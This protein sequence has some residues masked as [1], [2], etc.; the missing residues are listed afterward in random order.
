MTHP[1]ELLKKNGLYAGKELG[2]NFLSNP[3]TACMI[4]DRTG[5]DKETTVLE[6]GPGLGAI[7]LPLARACK[8]VVAVEKDSRIIPLLERELADEGI[9]NVT[10]INQNILKTNIAQIAGTEKL[11]VIGNLPYNISSQILFQ[12]I[13]IRQ[14]IT[15][16][17]LMFQKELAERLLSPPGTKNYSRLSAVVQ[18]ASKISRVTDIRP[19]NFFP[20]PEVD[21]TVLR[22]DFFKTNGMGKEDE[23]LLFSVIKAAFSKRRKTLHNAMSGGELGL[24]KKIVG[25]AL[26]NAG[27]DSSRRAETLTV[28][29]FIDLSRAV[30][31]LIT[32]RI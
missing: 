25:I 5:V 24:T 3:A 9:C 22:F 32:Q 21:S 13:T 4:V 15:H 1:G 12:L 8:Q 6:I 7:T 11:V 23:I 18:Y 30:G 31:K 20:R 29:E 26:K 27:I 17:F 14:V 19:N 10:I 16:A 28:Q 2:Q